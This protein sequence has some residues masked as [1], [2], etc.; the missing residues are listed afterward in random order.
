MNT[1]HDWRECW[2]CPRCIDDMREL[3]VRVRLLADHVAAQVLGDGN[4]RLR[5]IEKL[6]KPLP[7]D[8]Q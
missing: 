5:A 3:I 6:V 4:G 7:E 1:H 8:E 2:G